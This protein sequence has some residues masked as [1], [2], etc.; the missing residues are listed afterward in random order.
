MTH[1]DQYAG[2]NL[3]VNMFSLFFKSYMSSCFTSK[4]HLTLC[5][6]M[7]MSEKKQH[8]LL[9]EFLTATLNQI[10]LVLLHS[11]STSP[12]PK[13]SPDQPGL[14]VLRVFFKVIFFK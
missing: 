1:N 4:F 10:K 9:N 3:L 12:P 8:C 11:Q 7:I 2:K 13:K 14:R 5:I 6:S